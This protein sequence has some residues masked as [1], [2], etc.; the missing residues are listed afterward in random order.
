MNHVKY[1]PCEDHNVVTVTEEDADGEGN[2]DTAK[3]RD[4]IPTRDSSLL[5]EL[6]KRQFKKKNR[7]STKKTHQQIGNKKGTTAILINTDLN[8]AIRLNYKLN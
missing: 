2:T 6:T 8:R 7:N 3:K 1:G 4:Q 5:H